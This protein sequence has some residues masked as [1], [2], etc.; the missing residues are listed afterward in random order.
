VT[1]PLGL[2]ATSA[3]FDSPPSWPGCRVLRRDQLGSNTQPLT[4]GHAERAER[5]DPYRFHARDLNPIL[6]PPNGTAPRFLVRLDG[7]PPHCAHGLDSTTRAS[8]SSANRVC[9]N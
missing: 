3:R 4:P 7:R 6:A 2:S 1:L 9:T 8:A 5:P